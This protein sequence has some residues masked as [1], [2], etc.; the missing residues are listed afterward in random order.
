MKKTFVTLTIIIFATLISLAQEKII[1]KETFEN[2]KFQWDEF[3][4][5]TCS[6]SIEN[7]Y[8][9]LSNNDKD[10][11]AITVVDLPINGDRNFKVKFYITSKVNSDFWFGIVYDYE[12]ENNYSCFL[13]QEKRYKI[14]NVDKG[15]SSISRKG[16]IILKAGREQSVEFFVEKRG[17]KLIF[18]V[19]NMEV[20]SISKKIDLTTFGC[21]V[22]GN[23][24]IKVTGVEIEQISEED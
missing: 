2:N 5:K 21:Y 18:N 7:G 20:V 1:I 3:Y 22:E 4:E 12:D 24:S 23:N 15:I 13:V 8:L 11:K 6:S 16:G 19:D 14:V 9:K 17:T 10:K